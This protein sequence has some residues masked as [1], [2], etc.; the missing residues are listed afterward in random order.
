[1]EGDVLLAVEQ[2]QH[3]AAHAGQ[4]LEVADGGRV[5]VDAAD[6]AEDAVHAAHHRPGP[7]EA[8]GAAAQPAEQVAVPNLYSFHPYFSASIAW[9]INLLLS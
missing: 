7:V 1:V 3:G 2:V 6:A 5:D 4:A 9:A 8:L